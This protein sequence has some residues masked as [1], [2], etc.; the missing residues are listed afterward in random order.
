[1]VDVS[2]SLMALASDSFDPPLLV[3]ATCQQSNTTLKFSYK[4]F[5]LLVSYGAAI[6]VGLFCMSIGFLARMGGNGSIVGDTSFTAILISTRNES[7]DALFG[8]PNMTVEKLREVKLRYGKLR[9]GREAFGTR[10]DFNGH[11]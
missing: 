1:M 7:I 8:D 6:G 4:P 11:L 10:E 5:L 2:L 9:D 3:P